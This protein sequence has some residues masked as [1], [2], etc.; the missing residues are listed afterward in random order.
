MSSKLKTLP[1]VAWLAI[2]VCVTAVVMPTAAFA[3]GALTWTGIEGQDKVKANVTEAGQLLTAQADINSAFA[4][5][6]IEVLDDAPLQTIYA[7]PSGQAAVVTSIHV[8]SFDLVQGQTTSTAALKI[9]S[10]SCNT[11]IGS[12]DV[13]DPSSDGDTVLPYSPGLVIPAGDLL[14]A[15]SVQMS[16]FVSANGYLVP[17]ADA[18]A[19]P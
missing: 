1:A 5:S 18:P 7:P 15:L 6:P 12:V 13:V 14:C 17:A 3:S 11:L 10:G 2:G 16:A 19:T 8:S 4:S 9:G